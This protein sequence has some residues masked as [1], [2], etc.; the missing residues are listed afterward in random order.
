MPRLTP[1]PKASTSA[2]TDVPTDAREWANVLADVPLFANLNRRHLRK[3]AGQG[4]IRR[5]HEGASI[6][7]AGEPGDML[8]VVLDGEVSVRRRGLPPIALGMGSFFG[9]LALLD[10]GPRG[11]TVVASTP[12]VCLTI[13]RTRF[14]KLLHGEPAIAVA[15]LREVARRLQAAQAT[16]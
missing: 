3:V 5:I 13:G 9:E 1:L 11:A 6:V 12:V 16:A 10:E 8:Y 14:L 4:R 15:V 7:R 2:P